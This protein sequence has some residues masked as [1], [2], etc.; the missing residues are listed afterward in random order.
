MMNWTRIP[1][2]FALFVAIA[3]LEPHVF[4]GQEPAGELDLA[5]ERVMV[6]KDGY[7]LVVKRGTGVADEN[8]EVHSFE[9]PDSAV[10]GTFWAWSADQSVIGVRSEVVETQVEE[11]TRSEVRST[12]ELLEANVGRKLQLFREGQS[13][14]GTLL[15]VF[16]GTQPTAVLEH[17]EGEST[18]TFAVPVTQILWVEGDELA[19][20][21]DRTSTEGRPEKKLSIGLG[22]ESA[23]REAMVHLMYFTPDVRWIPT[24]R[25]EGDLDPGAQLSLQGELLNELEDLS[26]AQLDLVV[27]FPHFRYRDTVS[28]LSLERS[29]RSALAQASP[30][31]TGLSNSNMVSNSFN[32][33]SKQ[34]VAPN[35]PVLP[36]ELEGG[37]E[38]GDL[39]V[40]SVGSRQFPKGARLAIP[41]FHAPIDVRHLYTF[42]LDV[43]RDTTSKRTYAKKQPNSRGS[44]SPQLDRHQV[45]HQLE[46]TNSTDFPWTTGTALIL[47][48][49]ESGSLPLGQDLLTYTPRGRTCEL[50]V[51][52]AVNV[53]GHHEEIELESTPKH[54]VTE[55]DRAFTLIKKRATVRL[56]N[57]LAEPIQLRVH[58][59]TGGSV[60][61]VSDNGVVRR[62]GYRSGDWGNSSNHWKSN[63]HSDLAWELTLA[64]GEERELTYDFMYHTR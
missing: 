48:S 15:A 39:Y 64:P 36:N 50:P 10:L 18:R 17:V 29:M 6:F 11:K 57:S 30:Q 2:A 53:F 43:A 63:P 49:D 35:T 47:E 42:D 56:A 46:L 59:G 34:R 45:W 61:D 7:A 41:L 62:D 1:S 12:V 31:L 33:G 52:V 8:G 9:L 26:G 5:T 3:S 4:A 23:G 25:L 55:D 44:S 19:L 38:S 24:Y 21:I 28:P 37:E 13:F 22:S 14:E 20:E 51:T 54:L 27:G 32:T 60:T 16:G 40:F 58:V